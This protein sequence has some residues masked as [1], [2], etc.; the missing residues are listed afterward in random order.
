MLGCCSWET[1]WCYLQTILAIFGRY[2]EGPYCCFPS[3]RC[4]VVG[5]HVKEQRWIEPHISFQ[6]ACWAMTV[7]QPSQYT[8]LWPACWLACVH[9]TRSSTSAGFKRVLELYDHRL[10]VMSGVDQDASSDALAVGDVSAARLGP[11]LQKLRW[12]KP[13][14]KLVILCLIPVSKSGEEVFPMRFVALE[15]PQG[16]QNSFQFLRPP[17]RWW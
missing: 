5:C 3:C 1:A 14:L 4:C 17:N 9:K 11:R 6:L 15:G 8:S 16:P 7:S 10:Q 2:Q 12:P 13:S